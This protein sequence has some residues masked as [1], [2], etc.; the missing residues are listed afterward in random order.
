MKEKDG[1]REQL[2]SVLEFTNGTHLL[3]VKDVMQ[4]TGRSRATVSKLFEFNKGY[5]SAEMLA[6]QLIGV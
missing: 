3:S 6:R 2:Q 1:Y 5:I 4:F